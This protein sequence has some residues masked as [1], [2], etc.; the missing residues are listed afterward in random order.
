MFY[1]PLVH[2]FVSKYKYTFIGYVL[3]IVIFFPIEGLYCQ[4]YMEK[5]LKK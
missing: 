1:K 5:C 2:D 3:L 4:R